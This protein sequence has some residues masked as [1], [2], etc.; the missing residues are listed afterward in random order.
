MRKNF[1]ARL[2]EAYFVVLDPPR[3]GLGAEAAAKLVAL[4]AAEIAYLV[5]RSIHAGKRSCSANRLGNTKSWKVQAP[6]TR[7]NRGRAPVDLFP[8]DLTTID[9]SLCALESAP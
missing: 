7:Y 2:R 6:H 5:L 9:E 4:G 3:S 1:W 8:A